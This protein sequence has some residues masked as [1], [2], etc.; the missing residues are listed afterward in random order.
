MG[1]Q[2]RAGV[3]AV[4][5]TMSLFAGVA[6]L[7]WACGPSGYGVP[8][9]PAAPP[10]STA[11]PAAPP[12]TVQAPSSTSAPQAPA[13]QVQ[14]G[15]GTARSVATQ[16]RGVQPQ[17]A[18]SQQQRVAVGGR[19]APGP[20]TRADIGARVSGST[21]GVVQQ[22]GQSVFASSAAP[23]SAKA[24]GD[25]SAAAR[26]KAAA[27]STPAPALSQRSATGDLWSGLTS[28]GAS[29]ASAASAGGT[30]GGLSGGVVAA[31]AMLG[32]GLA[33]LTGAALVA[34]RRRRAGAAAGAP[35]NQ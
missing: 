7:S 9:T 30:G 21:A 13:V 1:R 20:A 6:G 33:G 10:T 18:P 14:V 22:R 17:R 19:T 8:A 34:G 29:L 11:Q 15:S 3:L 35:K 2:T 24:K 4:L 16:P 5:G 12:S 27:K 25:K 28:G 31:L 32:L 26:K 23:A